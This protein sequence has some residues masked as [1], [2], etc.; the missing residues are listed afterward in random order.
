MYPSRTTQTWGILLIVA[1]VVVP[2]GFLFMTSDLIPD[3]N[4]TAEMQAEAAAANRNLVIAGVV[5]VLLLVGG[6]VQLV[7]AARMARD[8]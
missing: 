2:G 1:A 5:G 4:P 6:V 8:E 7:R 3:Q